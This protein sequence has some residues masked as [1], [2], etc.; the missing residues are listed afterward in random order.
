MYF[1]WKQ[2]IAVL[3]KLLG[4]AYGEESLLQAIQNLS[5][6]ESMDF[7]ALLLNDADNKNSEEIIKSSGTSP[8]S[9]VKNR[10]ENDAESGF[11]YGGTTQMS[12]SLIKDGVVS[13]GV[14][15]ADP[16]QIE[17]LLNELQSVAI[18]WKSLRSAV[19]CSCA[20]PFEQHSKKVSAF[21]EQSA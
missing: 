4:Y 5:S 21:I 17:Q 9:H 16:V 18:E 8:S 7:R 14:N 15:E 6:S 12:K 19:I 11:E 1:H 10:F 2:R 20:M 3:N 13:S